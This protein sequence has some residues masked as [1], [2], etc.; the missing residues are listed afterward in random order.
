MG[1]A[2]HLSL[3][4]NERGW[5][6]L[7]LAI[8]AAVVLALAATW[9]GA[10]PL[11][12]AYITL[13]N[14]RVLLEG[15]DPYYNTSALTGATSGVHLALLALLGLAMPLPEALI[16]LCATGGFAYLWG[17]DLLVRKMGVE[18]WKVPAL[19]T[20]GFTAGT[21]PH[22]LMN[23]LETG[24]AMAAVA[25]LLVLAD[26]RRLALLAGL[27]PFIRPE[28]GLLAA[29]LLLRQMRGL[30]WQDSARR[31]AIA[32][33]AATPWALWYLIELGTPIPNTIAAKAAFFNQSSWSISQRLVL[34]PITLI[35]F[36]YLVLFLGLFGLP[37]AR[38]GVACLLFVIGF[39]I[40]ATA[41]LPSALSWNMGRYYSV[42]VPP[43]MVGIT[44]LANSRAGAIL[45]ILIGAIS[46][47]SLDDNWKSLQYIRADY[48]A[49]EIATKNTLAKIPPNSVVMVHDAGQVAWVRPHV[50]LIDLVG[51]KTP[52]STLAHRR[53]TGAS[54][55]WGEA[56]DFIANQHRVNYA[57]V[58]KSK[59][60]EC[61]V[62]GLTDEG[63]KVDELKE[64]EVRN[65]KIYIITK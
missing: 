24:I 11:D 63:W 15:A 49:Q 8:Y 36:N 51:L 25:W 59:F 57:I 65:Y 42:I 10:F 31:I 62:D 6:A 21:V 16:L 44:A 19:V 61:I 27:A 13:H 50:T 48:H 41:V 56:L 55:Y 54:C 64:L 18:G 5:L 14:A 58:I 37:R 47:A 26:D 28:L 40:A 9:G 1:R 29:L 38:A 43:F 12:D 60:W 17:I 33:L 4:G 30:P 23:G 45:V 39:L 7:R 35:T 34:L 46:F 52:S 53:F 22:V 3:A 2:I 20:I 32:A